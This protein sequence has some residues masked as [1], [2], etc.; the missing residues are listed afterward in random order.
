MDWPERVPFLVVMGELGTMWG[1]LE[2]KIES[3]GGSV[4]TWID[5]LDARLT[6]NLM[7]LNRDIGKLTGASHTHTS[8]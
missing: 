1:R 7:A 6:D 2:S 4:E 3:R 5:H 8:G